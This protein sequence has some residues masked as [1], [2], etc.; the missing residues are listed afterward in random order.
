[1]VLNRH[2]HLTETQTTVSPV[3][4]CHPSLHALLILHLQ[5][6][7][8]LPIFLPCSKETSCSGYRSGLMHWL[9]QRGCI[10]SV[11]IHRNEAAFCQMKKLTASKMRR[12]LVITD[13]ETASV[14]FLIGHIKLEKLLEHWLWVTKKEKDDVLKYK[15]TLLA[16]MSRKN[17]CFL[18]S[19]PRSTAAHWVSCRNTQIW[20][21]LFCSRY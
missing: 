5:V 2:L 9:H 21:N 20:T 13:N 3:P 18:S 14:L 8:H 12:W 17:F 11:Y 6:L 7:V 1:M 15:P 19:L 4:A 10:K 16:P